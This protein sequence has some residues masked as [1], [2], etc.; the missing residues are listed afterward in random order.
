MDR[1][2]HKTH[3]ASTS[4]RRT[5]CGRRQGPHQKACD[6]HQSR[7]GKRQTLYWMCSR[8]RMYSWRL[9]FI[10]KPPCPTSKLAYQTSRASRRAHFTSVHGCNTDPEPRRRKV[11]LNK[12]VSRFDSLLSFFLTFTQNFCSASHLS[13]PRFITPP[14]LRLVASRVLV[15]IYW[16]KPTTGSTMILRR[17]RGCCG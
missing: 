9:T 15:W 5:D 14:A 4:Q 7:H 17:V 2:V 16:L 1:A 8:N 3:R 10:S 11:K 13:S 6:E 12:T